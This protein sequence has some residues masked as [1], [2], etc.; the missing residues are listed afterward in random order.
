MLAIRWLFVVPLIIYVLLVVC[1][2]FSCLL[3]RWLLYS[4][5]F[6]CYWLLDDLLLLAVCFMKENYIFLHVFMAL[7]M[8]LQV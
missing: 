2:L 7:T 4:W 5:L 1:Y 6:M 3:C 8:L